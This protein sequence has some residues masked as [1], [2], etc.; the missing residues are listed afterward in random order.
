MVYKCRP[1]AYKRQK[2]HIFGSKNKINIMKITFFTLAAAMLLPLCSLAQNPKQNINLEDIWLTGKF[3]PEMVQGMKPLK[4]GKTYAVIADTAINVYNYETGEY[5]K[6]MVHRNELKLKDTQEPLRLNGYTLSTDETKMLIPTETESIYRHSTM[7]NFFV[8]DLLEKQ[9]SSLSEGG[10]QR[11]ATFSPDGSMIAFVRENNIYIKNLSDGTEKQITTDGVVNEII[12]GTTDWVYEEEFGF[13]KAFFWSPD[14]KKIAFYRFDE[15]DVKEWQIEF[16]TGLYP[17]WYRYRYPKTGEDNA[18]VS[19]HI[20]NLDEGANI[21]VDIGTGTDIY[22]PRMK[23]TEDANQ[24]A[25][26]R[27]NR[28]QNHLEILLANATTGKTRLLY[29]E[30]NDYYIDVTDDLYF[31]PDNK[32]FIISSEKDG[33]NH[34]YLYR[35]DGEFNKQLTQGKWDVTSFYGYDAKNQIVFYQS[36]EVSPMERHIYSQSLNGEKKQLLAGGGYN[37]ALFSS[38]FQFFVNTNSTANSPHIF[39]VHQADGIQLRILKDNQAFKEKMQAYKLSPLEFFEI[40]DPDI[41]LPNGQAVHLNAYS[42]KPPDF[43]PAK[44]YPVL[45]YVYGGPGS[46]TVTNSWGWSNY[47]WFQMLAQQGVIVVSVDNRGTGARGQEFKKMTY[48]ELGKYETEDM[49]NTARYLS[50]LDYVDANRIGIFGWSYGGYL[51]SLAITKGADYFKTAIAVAPVTSWRFYDNI[52]TERYMRSPQE[53][54]DGYDYNSPI[55]FVDKLQGGYLLIHG[56]ADD[57]VHFQNTMEMINALV[58]A[59]KQFELMVYPD[60][61]HGI[62]GGNTRFH[63]YTLMTDFLL[64]TLIA[65]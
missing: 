64:R 42:I 19:I 49:I 63:L 13:T 22:I 28:H 8:Y 16:Y 23:W 33:Y 60:R 57:N 47:F 32:H 39:S 62:F 56:S 3:F 36:S 15:S 29:E 20:H 18:L 6:T 25:V 24:L 43:D 9:L 48:L 58:D 45:V 5:V 44:K 65:E 55:H 51:S 52:Y 37:S 1:T 61:N 40:T 26:Q 31:L 12:N 59:N 4:D 10:K 35:M 21:Q 30:N 54:P 2:L 7:S 27:M 34:L 17:E 53:N 14:N 41:V 50:Q 11:L 38:D 46:Q